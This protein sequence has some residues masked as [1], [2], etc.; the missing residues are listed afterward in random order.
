[1]RVWDGSSKRVPELP[2]S[3]SRGGVCRSWETRFI[4]L[5]ERGLSSRFWESGSESV[6]GPSPWHEVLRTSVPGG[7]LAQIGFRTVP[8]VL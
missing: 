3:F 8:Q 7:T 5:G 6:L 2:E 1:M 4:F